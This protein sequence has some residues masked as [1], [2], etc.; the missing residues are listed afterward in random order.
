[1]DTAKAPD[2]FWNGYVKCSAPTR[3][4]LELLYYGRT[5]EGL[6]RL[7]TTRWNRREVWVG[8]GARGGE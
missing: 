6:R 7:L 1:M 8:F 4:G 2:G 5:D 3:C